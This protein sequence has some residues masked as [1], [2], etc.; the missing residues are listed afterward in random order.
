M[1]V[2][3]TGSSGYLG[4]HLCRFLAARG[5]E[6]LPMGRAQGFVLGGEPKMPGG[7][8]ALIHAAY[9]FQAFGEAANHRANVQGSLDLFSV[10]RRSGV[11]RIVFI[12][13]MAAF[14]GCQSIYGRG[15]LAVENAAKEFGAVSI[16]PGTIHG[17]ADKGIFGVLKKLSALPIVPLPSGGTQEIH[18][19]HIDDLCGAICFLALENPT[20]PAEPITLAHPEKLSIRQLINTLAGSSRYSVFIPI[21]LVICILFTINFFMR[22]NSPVRLDSLISIINPNPSVKFHKTCQTFR[23]FR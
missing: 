18:L 6:A 20:P 8:D 14:P 5:I 9:D 7:A 11:Q 3:V 13:S 16:R 1:K 12:S 23:K 21:P 10:A 15:K 4:A 2:A 17:G 19:V 22:G